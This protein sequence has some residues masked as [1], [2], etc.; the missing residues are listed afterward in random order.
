MIEYQ[1]MLKLRGELEKYI[2]L[3]CSEISEVVD[4]LL[5]LTEYQPYI[6]EE[7]YDAVILELK[8]TLTM[9]KER[10]KIVTKTRTRTLTDEYKE[11]EWT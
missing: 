9:F 10:T 7:F 6:S 5:K 2:E 4:T 8:D 11:L 3:E 1:E